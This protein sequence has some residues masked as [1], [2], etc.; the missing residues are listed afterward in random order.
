M[1][2]SGV[3]LATRRAANR[4]RLN[5]SRLLLPR[6]FQGSA[7]IEKKSAHG[8]LVE[9]LERLERAFSFRE[10]LDFPIALI[11]MTVQPEADQ[12]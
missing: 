12:P 8:E 5:D 7:A 3:H 1:H 2:P 11:R 6:R 4:E 9:P 10:S